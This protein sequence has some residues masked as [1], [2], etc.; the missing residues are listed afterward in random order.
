MDSIQRWSIPFVRLCTLMG[1]SRKLTKRNAND[2]SSWPAS[3]VPLSSFRFFITTFRSTLAV[4][5]TLTRRAI[6]PDSSNVHVYF[7]L[8][9]HLFFCKFIVHRWTEGTD[10]FSLSC[11]V[12][13]YTN[14]WA[15]LTQ[16]KRATWS[17]RWNWYPLAIEKKIRLLVRYWRVVTRKK[18]EGSP[19]VF[20]IFF[21]NFHSANASCFTYIRWGSSRDL[22]QSLDSCT[23]L[24][25]SPHPC[26][27]V[28][29]RILAWNKKKRPINLEENEKTSISFDLPI[30]YSWPRRLR[31]VYLTNS[32]VEV[33]MAMLKSSMST[34]AMLFTYW[35]SANVLAFFFLFASWPILG[36]QSVC[37]LFFSHMTIF[38][39]CN[40]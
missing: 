22:S 6:S 29:Q 33:L 9:T 38:L 2:H 5:V 13:S 26:A 31:L 36:P 27:Q 20:A 19:D 37:R 16:L 3:A 12:T 30:I 11:H 35:L 7:I 17:Q 1:G 10:N 23:T 32:L 21:L 24:S 18:N 14:I 8:T 28:V 4:Q 25:S 40:Q 34:S 39:F 15:I